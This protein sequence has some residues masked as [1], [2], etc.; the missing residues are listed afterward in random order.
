M[1]N[2]K[3]DIVLTSFWQIR[4]KMNKVMGKNVRSFHAKSFVYDILIEEEFC[5]SFTI[6]FKNK[7]KLTQFIIDEREG[8]I[9]AGINNRRA[10]L[11]LS[12][13][14]DARINQLASEI[15]K[16]TL[17]LIDF[18]ISR[19]NTSKVRGDLEAIS[20]Y[21]NNLTQYIWGGY[22]YQKDFRVSKEK[23]R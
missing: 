9:K 15:I 2:I 8:T 4:A 18:E 23:Y 21:D 12:S 14:S 20:K 22:Y 17:K 10:K 13:A 1:R 5:G 16:I 11:D 3:K 19:I 6:Y 7:L